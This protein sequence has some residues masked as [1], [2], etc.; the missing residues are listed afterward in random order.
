MENLFQNTQNKSDLQAD[1]NF[2]SEKINFMHTQLGKIMNDTEDLFNIRLSI[3]WLVNELENNIAKTADSALGEGKEEAIDYR[4][5]YDRLKATIDNVK[6][7]QQSSE[8]AIYLSKLESMAVY[9]E[10]FIKSSKDTL[11][12]IPEEKRN[13]MLMT[14]NEIHGVTKNYLEDNK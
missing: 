9:L 12:A 2:I 1:N 10:D 7:K 11:N 14:L 6:S 4:P 8:I 5:L 3:E 13:N